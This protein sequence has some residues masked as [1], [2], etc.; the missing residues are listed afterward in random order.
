[1][2]EGRR[3]H[4]VVPDR[5][6]RRRPA[7]LLRRPPGL[8][9]RRGPLLSAVGVPQPRGAR[10][11]RGGAADRPGRGRGAGRPPG[12]RRGHPDGLAGPAQRPDPAPRPRGGGPD[13]RPGPGGGGHAAAGDAEPGRRVAGSAPRRRRPSGWSRWSC[14][15]PTPNRRLGWRVSGSSPRRSRQVR[16]SSPAAKD[17][18][19]A[20]LDQVQEA[21]RRVL[22]DLAA[23]AAW[24][25]ASRSSSCG[26]PGTRWPPRCT[27]CATGWTA[28]WPSWTGPTRR[29]R[30]A[31]QGVADQF[32]LG[33]AELP[34][35]QD[36]VGRRHRRGAADRTRPRPSAAS[37]AAMPDDESGAAVPR[38]TSSSPASAPG[39]A[40]RRQAAAATEPPA[41]QPPPRVD[42][43]GDGRPAAEP[44]A[45]GR[46]RTRRPS[47]RQT[48][49]T[50][51]RSPRRWP[52]PMTPIIARRDELLTPI[53]PEAQPD[54]QAHLGDDQNRLLDRLRSAPALDA[55]ELDGLR[56]RAPGARSPPR[57]AATWT[58]RS[59]PARCSSEPGRRPF[60]RGDAVEQAADGTGPGRRVDA[61]GARWPRGPATRPTASVPP[62]GNGGASASSAWSATRPRRP[63]P[64]ACAAASVDGKVRWVV[65]TA[66]GCSDCE[67]NALAGAV[68]GTEAFPTGHAHP[69]AHSG[70]RC[71][72]APATD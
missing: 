31:A 58:R 52:S 69:P 46:S 62:S 54:D 50:A 47:S 1:M 21:R 70:C 65:T 68:S 22:A 67:D 10:S 66:S 20:L 34:H 39:T 49:L 33:T 56:G 14:W 29:P 16:R 18:G 36:E 63:S 17:E 38:S 53:T 24:P 41:P 8:R 5:H 42:S 32:R 30:A 40:R 45:I 11:A 51:K 28:S 15:W 4:L 9:H 43:G 19:R 2:A 55:D 64:P 23:T 27:G 57:R 59:P 3:P 44:A 7:F 61:C 12:G 60:R 71:L 48:G 25:R 35:D 37:P 13:R 72:I 6:R 26:R